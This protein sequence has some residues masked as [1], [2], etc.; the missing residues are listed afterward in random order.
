VKVK[1][2]QFQEIMIIATGL[3]AALTKMYDPALKRQLAKTRKQYT[4]REN[5][6]VFRS[7]TRLL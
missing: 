3:P 1:D 6:A 7:P 2:K 4:G 5:T